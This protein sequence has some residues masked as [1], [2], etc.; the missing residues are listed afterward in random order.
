MKRTKQY[1]EA[2]STC[3]SG[4]NEV[5]HSD[6]LAVRRNRYNRTGHL[7]AGSRRDLKRSEME[8]RWDRIS[9]R[10]SR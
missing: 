1:G 2:C 6:A 10:V 3:R 4:H 8:D 9:G 7:S 5:V